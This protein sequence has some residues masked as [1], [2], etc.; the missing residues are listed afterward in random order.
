MAFTTLAGHRERVE[1]LA[2]ALRGSTGPVRLRKRTSNLFRPRVPADRVQLDA[3][4]L[5][6]M[7]LT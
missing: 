7:A 2:A 5:G 4:E 3:T 1:R 6:P